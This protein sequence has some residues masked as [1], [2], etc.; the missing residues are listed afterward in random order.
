[1]NCNTTV[2]EVWL[3]HSIFVLYR[4]FFFFPNHTYPLCFLDSW[5]FR[6]GQLPLRYQLFNTIFW[7]NL[8]LPQYLRLRNFN[9]VKALLLRALLSGLWHA[10]RGSIGPPNNAAAIGRSA[11]VASHYQTGNKL[12]SLIQAYINDPAQQYT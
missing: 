4:F 11:Q 9:L 8:Q 12:I 6:L 1:M 5:L 2:D 10:I 3:C 7:P